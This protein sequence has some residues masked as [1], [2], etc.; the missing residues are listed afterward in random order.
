MTT[1]TVKKN[2]GLSDYLNDITLSWKEIIRDG[3]INKDNY[4]VCFSGAIPPNAVELLSGNRFGEFIKQAQLEFD[5]VIVDTAPTL[6][7]SDTLMIS[8][9]ADMTLFVVRAGFYR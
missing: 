7:V 3:L 4:K 5:I 2:K 8:Q 1:L 9:Y 6:P